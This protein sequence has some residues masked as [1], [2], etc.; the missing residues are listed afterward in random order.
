MVIYG[1]SYIDGPSYMNGPDYIFD[2]LVMFGPSCI[3][4]PSYMGD[5]RYMG[6]PSYIFD[7]LVIFGPPFPE[8]QVLSSTSNGGGT[9]AHAPPFPRPG[10]GVCVVIHGFA[11]RRKNFPGLAPVLGLLGL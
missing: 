4:G 7:H 6:G 3:D 5:P 10:R 2:H 11:V 8:A 9:P 1:P